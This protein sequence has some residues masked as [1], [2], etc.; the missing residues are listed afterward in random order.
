LFA[1]DINIIKKDISEK[2]TFIFLKHTKYN[3]KK[4]RSE[5]SCREILSAA[6]SWKLTKL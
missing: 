6:W 5:I 4:K 2:D 1:K 3:L